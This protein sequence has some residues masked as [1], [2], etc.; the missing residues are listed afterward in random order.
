MDIRKIL[1][2]INSD[3]VKKVI[4][5]TDT[6]NEVD[7]QFAI[8]YALAS[9]KVEVLSINAVPFTHD[10]IDHKTG[11]KMSYDEI[12]RV[13]AAYREDCGIPV[14]MGAEG[15]IEQNGGKPID[16]PAV[17]NIIDTAM[18][19]D[20]IVYI[21]GIGAATNIA[22]AIMLEPAIKEKICVI[23]LGGTSLEADNLGEYNLVQDY[24][25][26]QVLLDCG[27]PVVLCPAWNVTCV[28][29]AMYGEFE[30]EL[31]GRSPMCELLW[32][33]INEYYHG[34]KNYN[35]ALNTQSYGRTIWDIAAVAL[36][37]KPCCGTFKIVPA[38]IFS[39]ERIYHF[40]DSRHEIIYL[41]ALDRDTVYADAWPCIQ[42]LECS[43]KYVA[44]WTEPEE[45][46]E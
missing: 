35:P 1:D 21:L 24:T 44:R 9:D 15:A 36:L 25:A 40:D 12:L 5:D 14:Y 38:P 39:E 46:E 11:V 18:A 34:A 20:E 13:L 22:S 2:D 33:L 17:R 26:G 3:R 27:A 6:A 19:S 37:A 41:E 31:K 8:A 32:Q 42:G 28:L 10:G 45:A 23:W 4:L 7:D 16:C 30:R 29:Y 43:G